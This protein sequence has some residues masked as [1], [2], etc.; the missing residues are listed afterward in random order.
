MDRLGLA[1]ALDKHLRAQLTLLEGCRDRAMAA[2]DPRLCS[3]WIGHFLHLSNAMAATG[4]VIARLRHAGSGAAILSLAPLRLPGLPHLPEEGEG[5]P[6]QI[7]KTTPGGISSHTKSLRA[8]LSSP[9]CGGE[10]AL[11]LIW[12]AE[13]A[14][15]G[16]AE[17]GLASAPSGPSGHLPREQGRKESVLPLPVA[18][19]LRV[20]SK[21]GAPKGNQCAELRL[22]YR[23]VPGIRPRT[24]LLPADAAGPTRAPD[25]RPA[26]PAD[27]CALSH[28]DADALLHPHPADRPPASRATSRHRNQQPYSVR[29]WPLLSTRLYW[30]NAIPQSAVRRSLP[31]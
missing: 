28:P 25:S 11:D 13:Q 27:P 23:R 2:R 15:R 6:S 26:S 21:G 19:R 24:E 7:G 14:K 16:E 1:R 12:G 30:R 8:S 10:P 17:G 4:G 31:C 18:R 20:K 5:V 3:V 29:D 22:S 9:A